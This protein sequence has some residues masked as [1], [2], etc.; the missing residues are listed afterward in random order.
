M[1]ELKNNIESAEMK[2]EPF[3]PWVNDSY[4]SA[5]LR[6]MI[7]GEYHYDEPNAPN[8]IKRHTGV[9]R[10]VVDD[11]VIAQYEK[12]RTF[13]N[14]NRML[15]GKSSIDYLYENY[16][17]SKLWHHLCFCNLVQRIMVKDGRII[18]QPSWNDY[19][20]GWQ[21]FAGILEKYEPSICLF[22]GLRAAHTFEGLKSELGYGGEL[23]REE[24]MVNNCY[25]YRGTLEVNG[26][27]YEAICIRSSGAYFSWEAWRKYLGKKYPRV[28]SFVE[29]KSNKSI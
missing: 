9:T 14:L 28:I 21:D 29:E 17:I 25:P 19:K 3:V 27:S 18:E 24:Y 2:R 7:V 16:D 1:A 26:R 22:V 20:E 11:L 12:V 13:G 4:F 6:I 23:K 15:L 8:M 10:D 5:E